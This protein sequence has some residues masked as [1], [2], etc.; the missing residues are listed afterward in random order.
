MPALRSERMTVNHTSSSLDE[1][2][3]RDVTTECGTQ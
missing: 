3:I 2:S 1:R